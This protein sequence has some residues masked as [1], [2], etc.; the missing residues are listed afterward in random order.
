MAVLLEGKNKF[1]AP[2]DLGTICEEKEVHR[3][4]VE[5]LVSDGVP[6]EN[7]KQLADVLVEA[8][9]RGHFSHGLQ[10]LGR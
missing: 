2:D 7:A 9:K 5:S 4:I 10:R 6:K 3:F 1:T 8:D